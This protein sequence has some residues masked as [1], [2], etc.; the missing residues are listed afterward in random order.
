MS[1]KYSSDTIGNRTRDLPA[2]SAMPQR[3]A[4]PRAAIRT[5]NW[6]H[7][8]LNS[9]WRAYTNYDDIRRRYLCSSGMLLIV[10]WW[11]TIDV[12]GS[13]SGPMFKVQETF[14]PFCVTL[15]DVPM[16]CPETSIRSY[17]CSLS[18]IP[19]ESRSHIFRGGSL[20]SHILEYGKELSVHNFVAEENC[21]H[22]SMPNRHWFE[23]SNRE[24]LWTLSWCP[25]YYFN[26]TSRTITDCVLHENEFTFVSNF[27]T[28]VPLH[29]G[30]SNL[31]KGVKSSAPHTL[32]YT[33]VP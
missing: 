22:F 14:L 23:G 17:R 12:S 29:R 8:Y 26:L 18:N 21:W 5:L 27:H 32:V 33:Q 19:K 30:M 28:L 24:A 15:E 11:F 1:M 6:L 16:G 10:W 20:T 4:S 25:D 9:S 13:L 31:L 7:N 3:T 2:C